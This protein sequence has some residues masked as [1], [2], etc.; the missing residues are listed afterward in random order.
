MIRLITQSH[1]SSLGGV[2]QI[3]LILA[4]VCLTCS[5]SIPAVAALCVC[6]ATVLSSDT[7]GPLPLLPRE[8]RG[9]KRGIK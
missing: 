6:A 9:V 5:C 2:K 8:K 3:I 7:G 4:S 1:M